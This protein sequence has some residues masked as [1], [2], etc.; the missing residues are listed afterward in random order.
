M[1]RKPFDYRKKVILFRKYKEE[2]KEL[3]ET[4]KIAEKMQVE[5]DKIVVK[6]VSF[7]GKLFE[8]MMDLFYRIGKIIMWLLAVIIMS[9]GTV[10]LLNPTIREI[11]LRYLPF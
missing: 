10:A 2:H 11:I 6:K 8:V 1:R 9:T 3:M 5:K 7:A 4:Q